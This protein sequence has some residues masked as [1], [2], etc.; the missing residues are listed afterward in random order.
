MI[1]RVKIFDVI[2]IPNWEDSYFLVLDIETDGFDYFNDHFVD[3]Y[4]LK[5]LIFR[6]VGNFL[7]GS[8]TIK[9]PKSFKIVGYAL[10]HMP[11]CNFSLTLR[12]KEK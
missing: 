1:P 7:A 10:T 5:G 8:F 3:Q 11:E 6:K 9:Y 2:E 12:K 4:I